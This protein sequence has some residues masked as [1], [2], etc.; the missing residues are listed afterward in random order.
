MRPRTWQGLL[1]G[2]LLYLGTGLPLAQAAPDYPAQPIRFIVPLGPGSGADTNT[3]ALADRVQKLTGTATV[4]ENHPGADLVLGTRLALAAPP[5]GHTVL[6]LTPSAMVLNPLVMKDL[7]YR[8]QDV[9]PVLHL[10]NNVAVMV[11]AAGS[12]FDTLDAVLRAARTQPESV[13]MGLYGNSYRFGAMALAQ[14][15]R[16]RFNDIPYQGFGP[17]VNDVIGGSVDVALVDLGG[18]LPLIQSGKLR[19]L[20]VA[21]DAR[22]AVAP[23]I[24]TFQE[25]GFPGYTLYIFVGYGVHADTPAP[26]VAKI[27]SLFQQVASQPEFQEQLRRQAGLLYV[28]GPGKPFQAFMDAESERYRPIA[29]Q[30]APRP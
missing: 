13:S 16:V 18:A 19:A 2:V 29:A 20:A 28:G 24:P 14:E 4:V 27:E 12:R 7:P 25:S 23:D 8:P 21:S 17:T 3:R 15:A 26:I 6:L 10:T 1:S 11:T 9:R 30:A 5:D 22:V